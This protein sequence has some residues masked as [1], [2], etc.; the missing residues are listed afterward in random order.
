MARRNS[1]T[2][3]AFAAFGN[4]MFTLFDEP[5]PGIVTA[6]RAVSAEE[7]VDLAEF[8][9]LVPLVVVAFGVA[10]N[11]PARVVAPVATVDEPPTLRTVGAAQAPQYRPAT[12]T[13]AL[14]KNF[15]SL[16]FLP[17]FF[18]SYSLFC[19]LSENRYASQAY[20]T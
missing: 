20:N 17:F 7:V 2:V 4:L 19:I 13:H 1:S 14:V 5:T 15:I 10:R 11:V 8:V 18:V 12:I 16:I 9:V 6:K 3:E